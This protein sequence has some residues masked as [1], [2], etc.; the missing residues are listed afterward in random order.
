M[1][2]VRVTIDELA[3]KGLE[4]L[5]RQALVE[6]LRAELSRVLK[7]P[8]SRRAWARAHRTPVI[9]LGPMTLEP[10]IAGGVK[11]GSG[12]ARGI[13]AGKLKP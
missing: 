2:R 9:K 3:L 8:A 5:Q 4:P 7:D 1:S 10:G 6:G 11:F 13:I 12:L